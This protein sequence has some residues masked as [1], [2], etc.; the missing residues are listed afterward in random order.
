VCKAI[1][2]NEEENTPGGFKKQGKMAGFD[3]DKKER[4]KKL[5]ISS[6]SSPGIAG[7]VWD[8]ATSRASEG[9]RLE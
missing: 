3:G 7:E 9:K 2:E 6:N 1:T 5:R 8:F 4:I